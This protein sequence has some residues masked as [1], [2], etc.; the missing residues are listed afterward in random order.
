[1]YCWLLSVDDKTILCIV[2]P[3][4]IQRDVYNVCRLTLSYLW[5]RFGRE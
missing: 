3:G 5:C 4:R 1:M 2:D